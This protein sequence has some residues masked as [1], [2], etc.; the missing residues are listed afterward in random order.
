M[1]GIGIPYS[2][3]LGPLAVV[4]IL[5]AGL[6]GLNLLVMRILK[7]HPERAIH[8]QVTMLAATL[9][10]IFLMVVLIPIDESLRGQI[11]SL[12]GIV[13][14]ATIALSS[15]TFLGNA[16]A[17]IL[18]R[19][20]RSFRTGDFIYIQ[21]HFGRV[22]ARGLFH[23]E[24]QTEDRDLLTLP[25]LYV[26]TNPVKVTRASGTIIS[27]EVSLGYDLPRNQIETL[28]QAAAVKAGLE[29]PFVY[30]L[31]LGDFSVLY[32]V[33]GMLTDVKQ[34]LTS[35]SRLN[36]AIL[37]TLHS[38]GIEIVSP[39]F[40]N[41]RDV[42]GQKFVAH[43]LVEEPSPIRDKDPEQ[44]IFDKAEQAA[45]LEEQKAVLNEIGVRIETLKGTLA[46]AEDDKKEKIANMISRLERKEKYLIGKVSNDEKS[47]AA[48]KS[49][50]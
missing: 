10:A 22:S 35:R 30:I 7:D 39:N 21:N 42:V 3:F 12:L 18:L 5:V 50:G 44:I 1:A 23:I 16:L 40:M 34:L 8:R 15:T 14:S 41:T 47:M 31:K 43:S 26:T 2:N 9:T 45:T 20:V 37:D 33:N 4:A 46:K 27:A 17:G 38:A 25:N 28:L 49:P 19:N 6:I 24:I 48:D 29:D 36:G 13:I 32:R 11:L